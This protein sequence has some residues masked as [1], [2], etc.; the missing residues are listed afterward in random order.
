MFGKK[1][2]ATNL[3]GEKEPDPNYIYHTRQKTDEKYSCENIACRTDFM[4][5]I[6]H[7]ENIS[8]EKRIWKYCR[9]NNNIPFFI[10]RDHNI[11]AKQFKSAKSPY[12]FDDL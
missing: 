5:K 1:W 8:C 7:I 2:V 10:H 12:D 4:S 6:F 11:R 3:P 9:E